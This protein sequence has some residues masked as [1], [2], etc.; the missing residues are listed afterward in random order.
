MNITEFEKSLSAEEV[1]RFQPYLVWHHVVALEN[2][3]LH[4]LL[5]EHNIKVDVE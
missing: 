3:R 1:E 5:K 2:K 4:A